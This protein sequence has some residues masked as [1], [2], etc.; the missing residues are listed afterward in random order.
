ML[1]QGELAWRA[2]SYTPYPIEEG[3]EGERV[4]VQVGPVGDKQLRTFVFEKKLRQPSAI[5]SVTLPRPMGVVF[6]DDQRTKQAIVE[7]L[8]EGSRAAQK[9]KLASFDRTRR[10]EAL[11]PGDVLRGCTCTTIAY[12][13]KSLVFG[14]KPPQ[15]YV[16]MYGA[17]D[18]RWE[19]VATALKRGLVQ[20]GPV[21]LVVER[22]MPS[23]SKE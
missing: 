17:D 2:V 20:D 12:P 16:L 10:S 6:R 13:A 5:V 22:E 9:A 7:D 15:R 8:V 3:G 4:R 21:T 11:L 18:Q 14:L 1:T 23:T 19:K